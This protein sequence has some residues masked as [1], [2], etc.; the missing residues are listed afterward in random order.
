MGTASTPVRV[1]TARATPRLAALAAGA[2]P[3]PRVTGPR[4]RHAATA[5]RGPGETRAGARA[6]TRRGARPR[7]RH[8]DDVARSPRSPARGDVEASGEARGDIEAIATRGSRCAS[9]RAGRDPAGGERA[10]ASGLRASHVAASSSLFPSLLAARIKRQIK[11]TTR[12]DFDRGS[13]KVRALKSRD[14]SDESNI[15]AFH[16]GPGAATGVLA[17][18]AKP[19][20]SHSIRSRRLRQQPRATLISSLKARVG[21]NGFT[22]RG[23]ARGRQ[24]ARRAAPSASRRRSACAFVPYGGMGCSRRTRPSRETCPRG[25]GARSR[26][27][28]TPHAPL[29]RS[30]RERRLGATRASGRARSSVTSAWTSPPTRWSRSADTCTAGRAFTSTCGEPDPPDPHACGVTRLTVHQPRNIFWC[31]HLRPTERSAECARRDRAG[32]GRPR[33]GALGRLRTPLTDRRHPAPSRPRA[34]AHAPRTP[35]RCARSSRNNP[36][37]GG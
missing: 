29:A 16:A 12:L 32:R 8:R 6:S 14:P 17:P 28:R 5:D 37:A 20:I 2:S 27:M 24:R 21:Q 33:R 10:S 35:R 11:S 18:T 13:I 25:T 26:A 1:T 30:P 15:Y 31:R 4:R 3:T 9:R 7:T 22:P 19:P 34:L 36:Y 23:R